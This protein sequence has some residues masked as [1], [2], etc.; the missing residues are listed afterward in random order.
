MQECKSTVAMVLMSVLQDVEGLYF[1]GEKPISVHNLRFNV[2]TV[3][4]FCHR[5]DFHYN[6][7]LIN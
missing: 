6:V 2:Y 1:P 4:L 5:C 3:Y 7:L